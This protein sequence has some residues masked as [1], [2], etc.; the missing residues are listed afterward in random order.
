MTVCN[1]VVMNTDVDELI[2]LSRFLGQE[3]FINNSKQVVQNFIPSGPT[4]QFALIGKE[5]LPSS[6]L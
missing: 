3:I 4:S 5:Y 1:V 2:V 6:D